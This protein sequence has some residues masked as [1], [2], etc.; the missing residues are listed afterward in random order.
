MNEPTL[1]DPTTSPRVLKCETTAD[2]LAALP[3]LAGFTATNSIFIVFFSGKRSG[4]AARIDLPTNEDA[5]DVPSLLEFISSVLQSAGAVGN[6]DASPGIAIASEQTFVSSGGTPW[7]KFARRLEQ[8]LGR[9]DIRLRELCCVA[10]DGWA[11][12]R[13]SAA[14]R[15]GHPLSA[16]EES[17]I[18]LEARVRGVSQ[19]KLADMGVIP[20]ASAAQITA[21]ATAL[22]ALERFVVHEQGTSAPPRTAEQH[23]VSTAAPFPS[24]FRDTA[25]VTRAL[26]N[27]SVPLSSE[28]KARLIRTAN[29]PDR[30]LLLTLGILTRPEFPCELAQ[31]MSPEAFTG[32]A[33]DLDT[34]EHTVPRVGWSIRRMLSSICP[35]FSDRERLA[36]IR[37]RLLTLISET[38]RQD[39]PGLLALSAW[40]WW[41]TG[42][43]TVSRKHIAE[44]LSIDPDHELTL[45]VRRLSEMPLYTRFLESAHAA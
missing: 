38:P 36:I 33:I 24:W 7:R 45:M 27:E 42:T 14:P 23:N 17:P 19:P 40:V 13:D 12:Y 41:L 6:S 32:I 31:D 18:T 8:H 34:G 43:Q 25:E 29:T 22:D 28:L 21:V 30:W 26:R 44:A 35:D 2:F 3:Q 39:R 37:S 5:D 4:S 20:E 1:T 11:S 10:P 15:A 16:I 9:D